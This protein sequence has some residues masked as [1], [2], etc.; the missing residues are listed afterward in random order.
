MGRHGPVPPPYPDE[1]HAKRSQF[2]VFTGKI[3]PLPGVE[4][5]VEY[6]VEQIEHISGT[7][8][9]AA[10]LKEAGW[11]AWSSTAPTGGA[12]MG[13]SFISPFYN[14]RTDEYGGSWRHRLRF[15]TNTIRKMREAVGPAIRSLSG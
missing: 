10:M 14:R 15:P 2:E 3:S 11:T 6:T 8:L 12:T 1:A 9:G 5:V 13:C 4:T 7:S